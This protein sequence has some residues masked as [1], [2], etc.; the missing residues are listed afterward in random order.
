MNSPQGGFY[1]AEDADSEGEEGKFYVWT[2][3]E[4][5]RILGPDDASLAIQVFNIA[6]EGNWVDRA[7]GHRPGTNI[8][9]LS[10]PL[11]ELAAD[12]SLSRNAGTGGRGSG[13]A[14]PSDPS[15]AQPVGAVREPPLRSPA[16]PS[17][18]TDLPQR[19]RSFADASNPSASGSS[20]RASGGSIPTRTTRSSPTGTG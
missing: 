15:A 7:T 12:P 10:K 8:L 16:A 5:H 11:S 20:R 1:S 18:G 6:P 17:A 4:V 9:H 14:A 19:R 2:L 3:D 13:R